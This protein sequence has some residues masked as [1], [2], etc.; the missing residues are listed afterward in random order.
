MINVIYNRALRTRATAVF[1]FIT[2]AVLLATGLS[3]AS[4]SRD[5][6]TAVAP[7]SVNG[8]SAESLRKSLDQMMGQMTNLK[9]EIG[10]DGETPELM[11]RYDKLANEIHALSSQTYV[12]TAGVT[13][14]A[15]TSAC[16][17][18]ALSATNKT[19]Q[20][21]NT[22]PTFT[23]PGTTPTVRFQD[24]G[25]NLTGCGA[26]PTTVTISMCGGAGCAGVTGQNIDT[27]IYVYRT[28]GATGAGGA[29]NPFN[30]GGPCVN[31]VGGNDDGTSPSCV[32][33][34]NDNLRSAL[35]ISLGSG[36]FVVVV[37]AFSGTLQNTGTYNLFVDA[38]GASCVL[39]A[40]PTAVDLDAFNATG[41]DDG[42]LLE[43]RTGMEVKNLGFNVYREVGD[44]RTRLNDQVLG[45]SALL[46]GPS[47]NLRSGN[48]YAWTDPSPVGK[49]TRYWLEDLGLDGQSTWHGPFNVDRSA[50]GNRLPSKGRAQLLSKLGTGGSQAGQTS[51]LPRA[52]DSPPMMI[53]GQFTG[54]SDLAMRPA[55]KL[56]V[57]QEGWYRVSQ[58]E[59]AAAGF[60]TKTDPRMLQMFVDGQ[61]QAISVIGEEDGRFDSSDAIEFYGVG[62]DS[63]Y[64]DSRTYW[65]AS[66][67]QPGLRIEKIKGKGSRAMPAS[68]PYTVERRDRSIYFSA[69]R[70]GDKENFFGAVIARD[71]VDQ[72]ISVQH[73]DS[74]GSAAELELA[75]QGVTEISHRIRVEL[76]GVEVGAI[77]F[78][79][80]TEGT[81]RIPLGRG[82]LKEGQNI[83]RLTALGGEGD[84]SL[85]DRIRITYPHTYTADG[86]ALR[87]NV[88][89]K[90]QVSIEGFTSS[91]IRVIDVTD[92]GAVR[93][94]T[95]Q[96]QSQKGGYSVTV[97]APKGGGDRLL[98]AF[99]DS[100]ASGPAAMTLNRPSN[101]REP[102]RGADLVIITHSDFLDSVAPLK[103]ARESQ[104]FS[105]S[106]VDVEDI[107]DEFNFGQKS[108]QAV[109]DFLA[110]ARSN[111]QTRPRYALLVGD[112][113]L[114]PK[115]YLGFG[116]SDFVPTK[117]IDTRLME[118]ASDDWF[119]DF[120]GGG[121]AEM[122]IGRL[123]VRTTEEAAAM[124]AK[125]LGYDGSE[126]V[127]SVM[128]VADSNEDFD[129]GSLNAGL[130]SAIPRNVM[131]REIDR[132][133]DGAAAEGELIS[134]LDQG[135][136]IV[137]YVGHG[138]VDQWRGR[139]LTSDS[140]RDLTNSR[141][142]PLFVMMTCLNGYF[143]DA[144]LESLA[145]SLMKTERGGA[146]A[147]WASSGMTAPTGQSVLNQE[148][149][150]L[151]LNSASSGS[152][153][154]GEATVKAKSAASDIDIRRTWI[155][156][157]DPTMKLR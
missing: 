50:P 141:H 156:F 120:T 87:F 43:W 59:L 36:H 95:A 116:D 114:D 47:T 67:S 60:D 84:V 39:T 100:K 132:G 157:G 145:E 137:N 10:R 112:A 15:V 155:L 76:N 91:A 72:S 99:A 28:G 40:E 19:F 23:C 142:L 126:A 140:A 38:P 27:I 41:Y 33:G 30:I 88:S 150:R 107:Y 78:D 20:R 110:F 118:T 34:A 134:G 94:V 82:A 62:L 86:D 123:P 69:L 42:T 115:G 128:L 121:S 37:C 68:F 135:Q 57:K 138:S 79:G 103:A 104:G 54:Q 56:S 63:P 64:T 71:A 32:S 144:A 102:A 55:M 92:P 131:V 93:Q 106:V 96:V 16:F 153:T 75:L 83:V 148:M 97:S 46:V 24:F 58:S 101:L 139:L 9:R 12:Q 77:G 5:S 11:A 29:V 125:I 89:A 52:A 3:L 119:A 154:L 124:I 90:Q 1:C 48:S 105:V 8:P 26:F 152:L 70:N 80:Q 133:R 127:D 85:V 18:G 17:A 81:T 49:N 111:W 2:L 22:P 14:A 117:L 130:K 25:F 4:S 109:K 143:Q 7:V 151:V 61:E 66:G 51:P 147:V 149:F 21:A 65:L 45:G 53:A 113:S 31:L 44:K 146:V 13:P 98:L 6:R 129:F 35:T 74:S 73:L 122:A 136:K 108:P